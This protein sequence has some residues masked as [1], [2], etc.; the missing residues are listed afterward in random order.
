MDIA[1]IVPAPFDTISGGYLYDRRMVAG[2]RARGHAVRVVE[3]A[4]THPMADA[5]ARDAAGVA[6][7]GL[8]AGEVALVDG[9]GLPAFAPHRE[10]LAARGAVG[11]IHHPVSLEQGLDR[12]ALEPLERDLFA[13][14][15]RLVVTSPMTATTLGQFG[16]DPAR[17]SVVEPGTDPALRSKGSGGP[18]CRILAVGSIIP[19]KGHDVLLRALE[20]LTDLDWTLRIVGAAHDPVHLHSLQALVEELGLGARVAFLG[21]LDTASLEAEYAAADFFA[22]ATHYEGYGMVVAEA[23][24]RGL[25]MALCTGGAVADLVAPGSAIL[26]PPGDFNSLSR[27]MRRPILDTTLRAQMADA[28]WRAGQALPRWEDQAARLAAILENA[29]G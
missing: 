16:A 3:L 24:A 2:L 19:R 18:G 27:G 12:A 15:A 20:R 9:L 4:G 23:Q 5:A 14:C 6:L 22:L 8:R 10:A 11:L 28:A 25:P 1:L 29:H 7:A 13:A 26:A 21:G 17:V